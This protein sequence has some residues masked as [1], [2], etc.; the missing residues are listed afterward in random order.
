MDEEHKCRLLRS[1]SLDEYVSSED[2]FELSRKKP[3]IFRASKIQTVILIGLLTIFFRVNIL[4]AWPITSSYHPAMTA[5]HA[6]SQVST[7]GKAFLSVVV[8]G[9]FGCCMS[10][11]NAVSSRVIHLVFHRLQHNCFSSLD[12]INLVYQHPSSF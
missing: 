12:S 2:S 3:E 5:G 11:P 9:G 6:K 1:P 8:L 4:L 7:F 10:C